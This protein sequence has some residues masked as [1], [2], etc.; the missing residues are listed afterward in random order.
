[1]KDDRR[2]VIVVGAGGHARVLVSILSQSPGVDLVGV[3]DRNSMN[4]GEVIGVTKVTAT[5]DDLPVLFKQGVT[6]A[7]L[8]IGDN[9]ERSELFAGLKTEGFSIMTVKHP[10]AVIEPD[11]RIGEGS[12]ICAG[13][14]LSAGVI[15]GSGVIINTG[16][17]VDH[18]TF[19]D[20]HAHISSGSCLAGR[21]MI[22][23][24]T[25][26]GAGSRVVD[27]IKIGAR[28][29]IGAGSIVVDDIPS[30]VVAYGVPAKVRRH[31]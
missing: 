22:G 30:D 12:V 7:A 2:R 21:V 17:V 3:A 28:C 9:R 25:F 11:V 29:V 14:I 16:T 23:E 5:F 19:V 13:A 26:V 15:L 18:E 24:R 1:M 8:A 6:W 10:G 4:L 31:V 27:K 20:A